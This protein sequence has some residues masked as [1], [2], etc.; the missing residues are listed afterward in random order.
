MGYYFSAYVLI[1]GGDALAYYQRARFA[2][3]ELKLG[4]DFIPW[5]TSFPVS[6][7]FTYWPCAFLYNAAGAMGLIYFYAAMKES[8]AGQ[9][10]SAGGTALILIS[11]FIPSLSLW[12]SAIGKDSLALL[13]VGL[14]LWSAMAFER[15]RTAAVI[16]VI[17][18][19]VVRP[20][21]AALM[22]LSIGV[23]TI[24]VSE[25]KST[26]RLGM[27]A[28]AAAAAAFAIPFAL[29][30]S[31]TTKFETLSDYI[32]DRQVQNLGGGSSIDLSDMNPALRVVSFLYRPF[33]NEAS[34]FEQL[35]T[36]VDNILLIILTAFGGIAIYRAGAVRVF[37]RYTIAAVY[38]IPC[39]LLLSQVTAN[40]GLATRQK[41]MCVPPLL[42]LF[43]AAYGM[44]R[45][46]RLAR[47]HQFEPMTGHWQT[48]R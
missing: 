9:N 16:A 20:H 11:S 14:L 26:V 27:A 19:L 46:E 4:T 8:P 5:L 47:R 41:W 43:V 39:L 31:G 48:L 29:T 34:G 15:R 37:R 33:P 24:L 42:F 38:G 44:A 35:A 3:L 2:L 13:S 23:G 18:M 40:L 30:Y 25:L 22:M 21:I 36:S 10:P 6:L 32:G 45:A 12:T 7:G 17:V 1:H 28:L